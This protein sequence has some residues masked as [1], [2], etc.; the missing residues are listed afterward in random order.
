LLEAD[1]NYKV[2]KEFLA[3]IR[4]KALT[5]EVLESLTPGQQIVKI[6]NSEL[7]TT[8]GG[9]STGLK[10]ANQPPTVIMLV[11]LQGSGK[12]TTASKLALILRQAG[13]QERPALLRSLSIH[14]AACIS[15]RN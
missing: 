15:I 13:Q 6:V 9:V 4:E 3:R 5:A 7:T 11:G 14:K 1:V 2:V 8:L 10:S 12:T